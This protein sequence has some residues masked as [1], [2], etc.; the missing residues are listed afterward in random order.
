MKRLNFENSSPDSLNRISKAQAAIDV[1]C[2][3][4]PKDLTPKQHKQLRGLL[5]ERANALSDALGT[6]IYSVV[7]PRGRRRRRN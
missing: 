5:N 3:K 6:K 4:H 1:F 2:K 7:A